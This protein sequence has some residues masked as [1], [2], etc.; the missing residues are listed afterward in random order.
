MKH[1]I[2][3]TGHMI[4]APDRATPRFPAHKE[5]SAQKEIKLRLLHQQLITSL[6]LQG[7]ASGACGGD[8]LFHETCLGLN[9]PSAIYLAS[10]P[11]EFKKGSVSFAGKEWQERFDAL[12]KQLPYHVLPEATEETTMNVYERTNEW[13][14][15]QAL[16]DGGKNMTL[17]ALWDGGGG[18]GKGGTE[19]MINMAKEKGADVE[20]IDIKKL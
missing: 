3:F 16:S 13:M 5:A 15:K 2:L 20:V 12:L 14:L 1:Y 8:M 9:I 17:I 11:E 6:P 4:D 18:G 19:D 7:I 10:S